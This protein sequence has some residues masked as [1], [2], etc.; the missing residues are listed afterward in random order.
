M[1]LPDYIQ[2]VRPRLNITP[3]Q[4]MTQGQQAIASRLNQYVNANQN[5][6][7]HLRMGQVAGGIGAG[8]TAANIGLRGYD[9]IQAAKNINTNAPSMS[10][11]VF[12]RPTYG[13]LNQFAV[14]TSAIDPTGAGGAE[15]AAGGLQGA[16]A[17]LAFGPW[18]A[19]I[20]AGLG[21]GA[22]YLLGRRKKKIEERRKSLATQNLLSAQIGFNTA[23]NYFNSQQAAMGNYGTLMDDTNRFSNFYRY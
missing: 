9:D 20:G 15:I 12:G 1:A 21:A 17:G 19:L 22:T 4:A 11:D 16:Q 14:D 5:Y 8:M 13:A 18:G 23:T 6:G 10:L 7:M 3:Q 2:P